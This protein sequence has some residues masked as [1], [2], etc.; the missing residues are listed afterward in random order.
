MVIKISYYNY[1]NSKIPG[2]KEP[3]TF[4][5]IL[6]NIKI[7]HQGKLELCTLFTVTS[8]MEYLLNLPSNL[9]IYNLYLKSFFF[10]NKLN[11]NYKDNYKI[12]LPSCSL[13]SYGQNAGFSIRNVIFSSMYGVCLDTYWNNIPFYVLHQPNFTF[14]FENINP[15]INQDYCYGTSTHYHLRK[16]IKIVPKI[17]NKKKINFETKEI[18]ISDDFYKNS[19]LNNQYIDESMVLCKDKLFEYDY[20]LDN[21]KYLKH[22]KDKLY[23]LIKETIYDTKCPLIISLILPD[24][25]DKY[26]NSD[27]LLIIDKS[28]NKSQFDEYHAC[29]VVGYDNNILNIATSWGTEF[30]K[31]GYFKI[32]KEYL[33]KKYNGT[34]LNCDVN[35]LYT[36]TGIRIVNGS[37]TVDINC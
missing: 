2:L 27:G 1:K 35:Q 7:K 13:N 19:L 23:N 9:S 11:P 22:D 12:I 37:E 18:E 8:A 5:L 14:P 3:D 17:L 25:I 15:I 20:E 16:F 26:L 4:N 34:D 36:V 33:F 10:S 28:I 31:D 32:D 30:G 6:S 21:Y 29:L 24:N